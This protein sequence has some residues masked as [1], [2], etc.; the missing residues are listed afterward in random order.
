MLPWLKNFCGNPSSIHAPGQQARRAMDTARAQVARLIGALPEEIM[1]TGGG[2]EANNLAILGVV[3]ASTGGNS[4]IVTTTVEHQSVINVCRHIERGQGSILSI[5]VD[6]QGLVLVD[7]AV[8]LFNRN[9]LLASVMLANNEIGTIQ[10]VG[11]LTALAH[12]CGALMHTDAVQAV[13]KIPVDVKALGIDLLSFSAHKLH[14]P[15]GVGALY[16]RAGTKLAP[17]FFGG[18]QERGVRPG[19]ENLAAIV[20]FGKACELAL[21]R[22]HEDAA[23]LEALRSS[24]EAALLA[25]ISGCSINGQGAIRLPNTSNV[26]FPNIN[27][28]MLAINLDLRGLAVSTG[29]ACSTVDQE[30]SHVLMAMGQTAAQARSSLRF[31]FGRNNSQQEVDMAVD[32]VVQMVERMR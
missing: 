12:Q 18:H 8:R 6:S 4:L 21:I 20:G 10:P 23:Y 17:V 27:G 29:A 9:P 31:S 26:N 25:G 11:E 32:L 16:I 5:P 24:F 22:L 1:F 7:E 19:T 15:Q 13:G 2:T 30:P 14:G 3:A 28:E